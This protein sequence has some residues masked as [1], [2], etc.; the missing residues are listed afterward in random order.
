[1]KIK[2]ILFIAVFVF[3]FSLSAFGQTETSK[4]QF[5]LYGIHSLA[6]GQSLRVTL[7][8]PRFSETEIIPGIRV[9][10]RFDLYETDATEPGRLR[11]ARSVTREVLLDG[12]EA[13]AID[14]PPSRGE[15]LVSVSVFASGEGEVAGDGS[16][17]IASTLSVRE[18]GR[19]ILSLP[20]VEK[21]FDPQPDPPVNFTKILSKIRG[22]KSNEIL[23][24]MHN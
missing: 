20:A 7:Q 9:R 5:A 14:F 1:M 4:T 18:A 22:G 10:V 19:M 6:S 8:N 12:G 21:G 23:G 17:R 2:Q 15:R 11:L 16:V 24:R 13:G 3:A